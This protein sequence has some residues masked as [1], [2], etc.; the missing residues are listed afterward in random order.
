MTATITTT[1]G[2]ARKTLAEQIDRLDGILDGLADALNQAIVQAVREAVTVA[3]RAALTEALAN[4]DLRQRLT[5]AA[6][7]APRPSPIKRLL[8][9]TRRAC[10]RT[11]AAAGRFARWLGG[12]IRRLPGTTR[13]LVASG[14]RGLATCARRLPGLV[15]RMRGPVLLALSVGS[16][17]A[18]GCYV[19]GPLIASVFGGL[20]GAAQTLTGRARRSQLRPVTM[21]PGAKA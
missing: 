8:A 9:A 13:R 14:V 20:L 4:P 21:A 18:W 1:N 15:W 2:R 19:A 3:V 16:A 11:A 10:G 5:P 7:G 17:V 12:V 6:H